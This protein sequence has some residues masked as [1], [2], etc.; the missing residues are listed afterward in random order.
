MG[1]Q[2][3]AQPSVGG[4]SKDTDLSSS[5]EFLLKNGAWGFEVAV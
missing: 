3:Q 5:Y 4:S 1:K 2:N